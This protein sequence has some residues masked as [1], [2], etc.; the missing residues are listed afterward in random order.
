MTI[1]TPPVRFKEII[2]TGFALISF[3]TLLAKTIKCMP[4]SMETNYRLKK[5]TKGVGRGASGNL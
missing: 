2:P 4:I 3:V 5:Q 1:I